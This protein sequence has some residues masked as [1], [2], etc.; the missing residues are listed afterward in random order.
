[1]PIRQDIRPYGI[2]P[3]LPPEDE[4]RKQNW[5][6]CPCP[7]LIE[8]FHMDE[9]FITQLLEPGHAFLDNAWSELFPKKLKSEFRYEF[10]KTG[11]GWGIH[12]IED[13]NPL[14]VAWVSLLIFLTSGALGIVYSLAA[15]DVGAGFTIAAWFA[16]T[17]VLSVTCLQLSS[18]KTK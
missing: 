2:K 10:Q 8:H 13:L 12:I 17:A 14:A 6:Y 15:H 4:V 7:T 18:E 9:A 1:M 5:H 3:S 11:I 16:G